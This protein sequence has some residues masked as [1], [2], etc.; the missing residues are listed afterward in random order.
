MIKRNS[1][2]VFTWYVKESATSSIW[3]GK[4]LQYYQDVSVFGS[5]GY[6]LCSSDQNGN[7]TLCSDFL[8]SESI[9][10][11]S[12][13]TA[14]CFR[15]FWVC[16][17]LWLSILRFF[18]FSQK[19]FSTLSIGAIVIKSKSVYKSSCKRRIHIFNNIYTKFFASLFRFWRNWNP[20][21]I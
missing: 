12:W 16:V 17:I 8:L 9:P 6:E 18:K 19:C 11:V 1:S 10:T 7:G 21:L 2:C 20:F 15:I 13:K 5:M 3:N 4:C 14:C